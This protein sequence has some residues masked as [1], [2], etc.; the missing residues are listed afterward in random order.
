MIAGKR[1]I[2]NGI[3]IVL[4]VTIFMFIANSSVTAT[5]TTTK[6][7]IPGVE[8]GTDVSGENLLQ[9][10]I[11]GVYTWALAIVGVAALIMVIM[12]GYQ[13][14]VSAG[15]PET[16]KLAKTTITQ[17]LIGLA[18]ALS[19]FLILNLIDPNLTKLNVEIPKIGNCIEVNQS[20]S[21]PVNM[22]PSDGVNCGW[23][24]ASMPGKTCCCER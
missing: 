24:T 6:F 21:C 13:Y 14:M 22:S 18:V 19:I 4:L 10:Y 15:N 9:K 12:G 2:L 1:K 20:N 16:R 3:L 17:A 5:E 8:E 23:S 11:Q 7:G